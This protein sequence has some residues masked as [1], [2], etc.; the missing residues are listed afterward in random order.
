M[1]ER[2]YNQLDHGP[3]EAWVDSITEEVRELAPNVN[4]IL[5][6]ELFPVEYCPCSGKNAFSNTLDWSVATKLT[7]SEWS[8]QSTGSVYINPQKASLA[9]CI[10]YKGEEIVSASLHKCGEYLVFQTPKFEEKVLIK[11]RPSVRTQAAKII[12]KFI[13]DW[14]PGTIF[15]GTGDHEKPHLIKEILLPTVWERSI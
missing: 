11:R 15:L 5:V 4:L 12:Q 9:I 10:G 2:R 1:L 7:A 6:D 14:S 3:V 13:K 8:T